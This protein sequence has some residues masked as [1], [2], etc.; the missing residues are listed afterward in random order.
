[1]KSFPPASI[2]PKMAFLLVSMSA[3]QVPDLVLI[4]K[5]NPEMS[6][7]RCWWHSVHP[8][9]K[10]R[11]V[12]ILSACLYYFCQPLQHCIDAY[13][14]IIDA[15]LILRSFTHQTMTTTMTVIS[16]SFTVG[17]MI[18]LTTKST[19]PRLLPPLLLELIFF[20]N[21]RQIKDVQSLTRT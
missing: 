10:Q 4:S 14:C 8:K 7:K 12:G 6:L 13:Q 17:P 16:S 20:T 5:P 21:C 9:C 2:R 11:C 15:A 1:M 19:K 3:C 18:S